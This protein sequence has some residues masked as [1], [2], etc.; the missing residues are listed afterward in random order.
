VAACFGPPFTLRATITDAG[1]GGAGGQDI[2]SSAGGG[3][4]GNGGSGGDDGT[5]LDVQDKAGVPVSGIKVVVNDEAGAVVLVTET[6]GDGRAEV[7]IPNA[8]SVSVFSTVETALHVRTLVDPPAG[9]TIPVIVELPAGPSPEKTLYQVI[10]VGERSPGWAI[11]SMNSRRRGA[12]SRA[13]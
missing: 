10:V 9:L 11:E 5:T 4:T 6:G 8:G 12:T 13:R 2:T 7:T 3:Q 1:E